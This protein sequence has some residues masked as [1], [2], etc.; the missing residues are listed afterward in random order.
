MKRFISA[1]AA[2]FFLVVIPGCNL[3]S[4][5]EDTSSPDESHSGTSETTKKR[6]SGAFTLAYNSQDSLNPYKVKTAINLELCSLFVRRTDKIDI[7]MM[8]SIFS[9]RL[10]RSRSA[11]LLRIAP[12][13]KFSDGSR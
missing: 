4:K 12:N 6:T 8:Q 5:N 1:L 3:L 2:L 10:S 7:D 13:A 11:R 9:P